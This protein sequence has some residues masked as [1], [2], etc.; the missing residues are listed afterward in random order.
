M[1]GL[2][3]ELSAGLRLDAPPGRAGQAAQ[4]EA[5]GQAD[6]LLLDQL[7]GAV[8]RFGVA[9]LVAGGG[10]EVLVLDGLRDLAGDV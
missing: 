8:G 3:D 4:V 5:H 9:L 7:F 6:G 10:D 1:G 2:L